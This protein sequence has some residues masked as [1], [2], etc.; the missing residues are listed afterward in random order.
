MG[1]GDT[2]SAQ[3]HWQRAA[4]LL[5]PQLPGTRDWRLL[6]PAARVAVLTGRAD[7]ARVIIAQLTAIGYVP[8]NPM[9]R[10]PEEGRH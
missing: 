6:D 3:R 7:E 8:L 10:A 2:I 9:D 5:V 1:G 4:D